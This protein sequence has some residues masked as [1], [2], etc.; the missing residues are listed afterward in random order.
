[1]ENNMFKMEKGKLI[2]AILIIGGFFSMLNET[3]LNVAFPHIMIEY[4][5]TAG[6]VQWLTTAYVLVSGIV[7]LMTAFLIKKYTTRKLF[8]SA[9]I[10]MIIGTI[11]SIIST[12]FITLL[13]G[14]IIQALGTGIIVPLVF[15]SVMYITIP[16]KRG[17]MM[18]I[19]SLVVLSAPIFAPVLM[20]LV[21]EVTDWHAY[22]LLMLVLF[23]ISA[24]IASRKLENITETK[25]AKLDII[26]LILAAI[27]CTLV[28]YGFSNLGEEALVNVIITLI[29]GIV[30]IGLF[31]YRQLHIDHP[32]LGIHVFKD[33]LFTIGV[34]T[35]LGNIMVIFGIVILIPM[36]LETAIHTSSLTASLVMLPGTVIGSILP[37]ISG[38]IYDEHGPRIVICTGIGIMVIS[39][40][41]LTTLSLNTGF[42]LLGLIICGFYLGSGL[43]LSPN[44]T[45]TL[46]NLKSEDYASGSAILTSTQQIGG[47]VGSSLFTS[48]MTIGQNRYLSTI[49]N[50]SG[51][52]HTIALVKGVNFSFLIAG[53]FLAVIF[54]LKLF[55]K[56]NKEYNSS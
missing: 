7:F 17:L 54:V 11:V 20:G 45:N 52:Q 33:K 13:I 38:H 26:S 39:T 21:M 50:P 31:A 51:I 22:F 6:T 56:Q 30:I 5:I 14:R 8:L 44:Q 1:M 19:V 24:L 16:Q 23:I 53:I 2:I 18:G 32:L 43:S 40:F 37:I 10:L 47:A 4:G 42:L 48:F 35:N 25:P 29:V 36:Y 27:G 34:L 28:I 41:A 12:S 3:A 49:A 55:L 15:N 9:M 46:G